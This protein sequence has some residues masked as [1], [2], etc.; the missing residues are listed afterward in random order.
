MA[1]APSRDSASAL[2]AR[3]FVDDY[4]IH[5]NGTKAAIAA[6]YAPKSARVTASQLLTKPNIQR[7]IQQR[8][9]KASAKAEMSLDRVL[10]GIA[11]NCFYDAVDFFDEHGNTRPLREIPA[12]LRAAIVGIEIHEEHE[13]GD[14]AKKARVVVTKKFKLADKNAALQMAGRHYKLFTDKYVVSGTVTLEDAVLRAER[15]HQDGAKEKGV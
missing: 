12:A 15:L 6:G 10:N 1:S 14:G 2:K 13:P 8:T 7:M 4:I 5:F 3:R 11:S 9:A